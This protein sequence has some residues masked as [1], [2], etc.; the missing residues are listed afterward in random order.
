MRP[1]RPLVLSTLAACACAAPLAATPAVAGAQVRSAPAGLRFFTP[2][3]GALRSTAHGSV[4]WAR[5]QTGPDALRGAAS[6]RLVLYRSI[7]VQGKPLAVSGSVSLPKGRAPRGGWPVITY[8]HGTT[9]IA[10]A[11]AP[12]R[13]PG[14][15]DPVGAYTSYVYPLLRRWLKA[16]YAVVRTDYEGLGTPG[17]HPYLIGRS[18][19]RSTLDMV[20]AA[21]RVAPSLGRKVIVAGHS[22]GGHAALWATALAGSWTPELR[23]RGTVAFAPASHLSEQAA[24]LPGLTSP[25][26]GLSSLAALILRAVDVAG[27][28]VDVPALLSPQAAALYPQTQTACLPAL[29]GPGS[30]GGLA[31]A[32]LLAPGADPAPLVAAIG[33]VI[34]PEQLRL[35]TPVLIP[36]GAADGT[37]FPTFT[38]QLDA[39]LRAKGAKVTYRK[40]AGVDHAGIVTAAAA[41]ATR[42]IASRLR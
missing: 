6:N 35:R 28:E 15:A 16:G 2:P 10:D 21:R 41:D 34:D 1:L 7:G 11:C 25:G 18:E 37:V 42:Y 29:S 8:A 14:A 9:G 20:R 38:D 27:A 31:P 5:R 17:D 4:I 12:T 19:G 3:T 39:E 26:G 22:Q 33:R 30:F 23:V 36:Q 13:S 24:L 32:A 40:Y